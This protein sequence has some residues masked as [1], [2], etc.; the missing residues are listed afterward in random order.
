MPD[1]MPRPPQPEADGTP[2]WLSS[3]PFQE[4]VYPGLP[5]GY[6]P[7]EEPA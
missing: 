1:A 3:W 4:P 2:F 5:D 7:D 6:A